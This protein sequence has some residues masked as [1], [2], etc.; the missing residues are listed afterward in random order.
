M[1]VGGITGQTTI[2]NVLDY[3]GTLYGL[4]REDTPFLAMAGGLNGGKDAEATIFTWQTYDLR[5]ASQ[6]A[7][8][9]GANAPDAEARKRAVA[10]NI[11]QIHHETI[12]TSYT[13]QAV[14]GGQ[15]ASTGSGHAGSVG[16]RGPVPI[17]S[18]HSWQTTQ[19]LKQIARDIE[20]SY[21]RG[22]F[23]QPSDSATARKTRGIIEACSTNV[24][25]K[26]TAATNAS[27][28]DADDLIDD[29]GH[30]LSDGDQIIVDSITGGSGI[31]A[32]D[33]YYVD[34]ASAD[35]FYLADAL[36]VASNHVSFGADITDFDYTLLVE[37]TYLI[38]MDFMQSVWDNGGIREDETRTLWCNSTLKRYLTKLLVTDQGFQEKER[39]VA[40][41]GVDYFQTDFG[42]MNVKLH[43]MM[44]KDTILVTSMEM[45]VPRWLRDPDKPGRLFIEPL[46]KAGSAEKDQLYGETGLEYGSELAHGK[47]TGLHGKYNPA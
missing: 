6:P 14:S 22:T 36:P 37:P 43:H 21:L 8:V 4:T 27:G 44:P 9:E 7:R 45:M 30:G 33:V 5:A 39:N 42:N 25:A 15:F 18:E 47:I 46:G 3:E 17:R 28:E 20:Y 13:K 35:T 2:T 38:L 32:G 10:F 11:V 12:E 1:A 24:V 31:S 16:V 26:G 41:V 40:G 34:Q 29:V 19:M 23:V